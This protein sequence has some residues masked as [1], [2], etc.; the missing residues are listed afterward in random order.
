MTIEQMD[1]FAFVEAQ[2]EALQQQTDPDIEEAADVKEDSETTVSENTDAFPASVDEEED[3]E[4]AEPASPAPPDD[5]EFTNAVIQAAETP[6]ASDVLPLFTAEETQTATVTQN[7]LKTGLHDTGVVLPAYKNA[8]LQ[9]QSSL[10][11]A[12]VSEMKFVLKEDWPELKYQKLLDAGMEK[13]KVSALRALRETMPNKPRKYRET[14]WKKLLTAKRELAIGILHGEYTEGTF[15]NKVMELGEL[16]KETNFSTIQDPNRENATTHMNYS[17]VLDLFDMYQQ[18][19]HA[20]SLKDYFTYHDFSW[21]DLYGNGSGKG[22]GIGHFVSRGY[23]GDHKT[24]GIG[25]YLV[26]CKTYEILAH[27]LTSRNEAFQQMA[28]LLPQQQQKEATETKAKTKGQRFHITSYVQHDDRSDSIF[29]YAVTVKKGQSEIPLTESFLRREEAEAYR[30]THEKELKAT[31]KALEEP[32]ERG[33][34]DAPRTGTRHR[35]DG[36]NVTAQELM[37]TF[38]FIGVQFGN[39]VEDDK[40]QAF[41]NQTYDALLDLANAIHVPYQALSLGK[42]L[43]LQ[44]GSAGRGGKDAAAA[45]FMPSAQRDADGN[46]VKLRCI[47]LTKKRG[48]GCLAHEWFHALDN[49]LGEQAQQDYLSKHSGVSD[50]AVEYFKKQ[51][52]NG[53]YYGEVPPG[54]VPTRDGYKDYQSK[55]LAKATA[56]RSEV[57]RGMMDATDAVLS[58]G[59]YTRSC[60]RD[61]TR[62]K[63]YW[64]TTV[65]MMARSFESYVKEAL[66]KQGIRNDFLVNVLSEA[67]WNKSIA[68]QADIQKKLKIQPYVYAYPT[69]E[70]L[71]VI[72]KGFTALFSTLKTRQHDG[73]TELF[74]CT[75][76]DTLAFQLE[77]SRQVLPE[78]YT[79][80]ERNLATLSATIGIPVAFYEGPETLHGHFNPK[81]DELYL[82][83]NS[84]APLSWVFFHEAFHVL[85]RDEPKLYDE[86]LA[87]TEQSGTITEA[88][89]DAFRKENKAYDMSDAAIKEE[90]LANAFADQKLSRHLLYQMTEQKPSLAGRFLRFTKLLCQ[91]AKHFLSQRQESSARLTARQMDAF[92]KKLDAITENLTVHGKKPLSRAQNILLMGQ[93]LYPEDCRKITATLTPYFNAP[94]KQQEHDVQMTRE[95]LKLYPAKTVLKVLAAASPRRHEKGYVQDVLKT[96]QKQKQGQAAR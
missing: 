95:L 90:L 14:I 54:S 33:K 78:F 3:A 77:A 76:R 41:V 9:Y 12:S 84:E 94:R 56:I 17:R 20:N 65:E 10:E 47:N 29:R 8:F 59:L 72:A 70:E 30:D 26:P 19:G 22:Y 37:D 62:T 27:G 87:F 4:L 91:K 7:Q 80:E 85:R 75:Q 74:S 73:Q 71:P 36:H 61:K 92:G 46:L 23:R 15:Y 86:L 5:N 88:Q 11:L 45:H 96:A 25:N 68:A 49:Y 57:V 31:L 16:I 40:R 58:T 28:T 79:S 42:T 55:K 50:F 83:R 89:L 2:N 34:T 21:L 6:T 1:L 67:Q 35:P 63:P 13:W 60:Q 32:D 69:K 24:Y 64:S 18:F 44:F 38:G 53:T 93:P 43:G 39:W 66:Q 52:T 82:N 51:C 48:G 81:T